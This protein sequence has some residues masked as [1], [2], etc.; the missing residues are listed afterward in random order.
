MIQD[1]LMKMQNASRVKTSYSEADVKI[2]LKDLSGCME[3]LS[4]EE[5]EEKIQNGVH[6]SEMLPE[7]YAPSQAYMEAYIKAL[8]STAGVNALGVAVLSN[9]LMKKH[10]GKFVAISLARA[11]LPIG[12]LIKRYIKMHYGVDIPHYGISIIRGKGI[13]KNAL[14]YIRKENPDIGVEH[15]QFIDGWVGKGAISNILAE[16]CIDLA[17]AEE[18]Q[19]IHSELAV[20]TDPANSTKLC[21]SHQDF[22]IASSCLNSTVS[23]LVSRTILNDYIKENDFHGAVYF[24][25]LESQ[26]RSY[27]FISVIEDAFRHITPDCEAARSAE[28][29]IEAGVEKFGEPGMTVVKRI[30]EEFNIQDVNMIKPSIGETTRVLLRRVPWMVLINDTAKEDDIRHIVELCKSKGVPMKKYALGN[31]RACGIIKSLKADI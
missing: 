20:I 19:G 21:G 6:Y 16:D 11:G 4:A 9:M 13:D 17:K 8:H 5:R 12:I 18:W 23:G 1:K 7:E 2:L 29:E 10:G 30:Q 3:A 22:I 15:F 14:E 28:A 26:D 27:E 31:Y 25:D 24:K